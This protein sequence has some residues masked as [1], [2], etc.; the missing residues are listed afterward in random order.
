MPIL[1]CSVH[2]KGS[3]FEKFC[4]ITVIICSELEETQMYM[5]ALDTERSE[6]DQ[7]LEMKDK[8]LQVRKNNFEKSNINVELFCCQ[9]FSFVLES[10]VT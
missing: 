6:L 4:N 5:K 2:H 7:Q 3:G 8:S 9:N 10:V 1:K